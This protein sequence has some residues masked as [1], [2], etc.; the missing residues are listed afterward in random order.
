LPAEE[1]VGTRK[2]AR[3]KNADRVMAQIAA[4]LPIEYRGVYIEDADR[5]IQTPE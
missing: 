4:L 3:Q 5:I 1:G 2:A